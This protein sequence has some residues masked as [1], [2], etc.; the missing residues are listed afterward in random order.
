[1]SVGSPENYAHCERIAR[2]HDRDRWLA[3]LFAPAAARPHLNALTA[4]DCE[5]GGIRGRVREPLAG[6][7]RLAWWRE[8]FS[9]A[10]PEEARGNPIAGALLETIERFRLPPMLFENAVAARQFDVYDDAMPTLHDLEGYC[11]ETCSSLFQLGALILAGGRDA[12]AADASGHAG[13]AFAITR[14]LLALPARAAYLPRDLLER[15]GVARGDIDE[16]GGGAGLTAALRELIAAARAHLAKAETHI[17]TLPAQVAPAYAPLAVVPVY[18]ARLARAA[19]AP[20]DSPIEVAQWR[21]QW[22][23]WRW[24]RRRKSPSPA[25]AGEGLG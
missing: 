14:L 5:L 19:G 16:R 7:M 15:H 18:L 20:F 21:R 6:E 25:L 13:V 17:E 23:L 1:V 4:F 12:G 3:A 11:G 10:R 8:A 2:E 9:G 22:A 24:A